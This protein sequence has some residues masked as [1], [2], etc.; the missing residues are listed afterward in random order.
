MTVTYDALLNPLNPAKLETLKRVYSVVGSMPV[1][2]L[3]AFARDL[4]FDHIHGIEA[5]RATMDI[6]TCV[7]MAS[8]DDFNAACEKLKA[9]G[10]KN[11]D[12]EHPEKFFDTNG[13]EVDLLPFGSLSEDGKT[14]TWPQDDNPWT[15]T[16]IQEAYEHATIIRMDGLDLR[17]IPP[18]AM[19]YL[20]MFSTYDR[21][22]DRRKKDTGDIQFVLKHYLEVVGRERLRAGGS[23]DDVMPLVG[24]DLHKAAAPCR[25]ARHRKDPVRG[26]GE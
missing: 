5:P 16:G 4:V 17:V 13:Q 25:W 8:W 24:G 7:Q 14:I 21:P 26:F 1:V 22:D 18:C 9:L 11:E 10:F 12:A 20:K 6:D 19:I 3:G 23:D 2:I 15:I